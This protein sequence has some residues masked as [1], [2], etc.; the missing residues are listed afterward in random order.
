MMA[1]ASARSLP[2]MSRDSQHDSLHALHAVTLEHPTDNAVDVSLGFNQMSCDFAAFWAYT[3]CFSV[4]EFLV[5]AQ[6]YS[7]LVLSL[8]PFPPYDS[9]LLVIPFVSEWHV[10]PVTRHGCVRRYDEIIP[11]ASQRAQWLNTWQHLAC[12][13][14]QVCQTFGA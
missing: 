10:W 4:A 2:A 5:R 3:E 14:A 13:W 1:T 11:T 7:L 6:A 8:P 9:G 12:Q